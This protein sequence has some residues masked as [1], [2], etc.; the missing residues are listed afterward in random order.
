VGG[1]QIAPFS[2]DL[3]VVS[4]HVKEALKKIIRCFGRCAWQ[5]RTTSRDELQTQQG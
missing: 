2:L 5:L 1:N 3:D 4:K